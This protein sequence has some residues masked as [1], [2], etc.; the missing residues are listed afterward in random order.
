M[1]PKGRLIV[2]DSPAGRLAIVRRPTTV[3]RFRHMLFLAPAFPIKSGPHRN[4]QS[5]PESNPH[6]DVVE[7][8]AKGG[9]DTNA[10]RSSD[11]DFADAR[12]L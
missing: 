10:D 9:A 5:R 4:A 1:G 3:L 8:H 12:R 11:P 2:H 6:G 7:R